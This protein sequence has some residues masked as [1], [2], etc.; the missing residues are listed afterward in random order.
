[1]NLFKIAIFYF[2][3][4]VMLWPYS[5]LASEQEHEQHGKHVHGEG[6]LKLV[7]EKQELH[8]EFV[9]PAMSMVG[10]EHRAE[11]SDQKQAVQQAIMFLKDPNRV[12]KIS[13]GANCQLQLSD[14]DFVLLSDEEHHEGE[15]HHDGEE[16]HE[17]HENEEAHEE[18]ESGHAEFQSRYQFL[19]T[20][21]EKLEV[22]ELLIF[23]KF[24]GVERVDVDMIV[25][26]SQSSVELLPKKA[27]IR[28]IEC[29]LG[30][31]SWCLF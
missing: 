6:E 19:C 10:F 2:L 31:G 26:S 8:M 1:M 9:I 23:E 21:P 27:T 11:T 4:M 13:T 30:I 20:N 12:F 3:A 5:L 24:A 16:H 28:L 25:S 7:L 14:A 29:N 18:H 17:E 22:I 15:E